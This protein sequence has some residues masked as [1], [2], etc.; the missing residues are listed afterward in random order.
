M[1]GK[2]GMKSS[3]PTDIPH[4]YV[5]GFLKGL[6]RRCRTPRQVRDRLRRLIDRCGGPEKLDEEDL[7]RIEMYVHHTRVTKRA[8]SG[9][10]RGERVDLG[11]L[12][13]SLRSWL[14]L[15]RRIELLKVRQN[16]GGQD[17][18]KAMEAAL[19]AEGV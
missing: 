13:D 18:A 1:A 12:N 3:K 15:D 11:A 7:D 9:D 4:R 16:H 14:A 10:L 8:A 6:D 19:R 17:L 2:Q 5:R